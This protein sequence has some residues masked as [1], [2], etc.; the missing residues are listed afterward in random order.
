MS[1]YIDFY[2]CWPNSVLG[3]NKLFRPAVLRYV[4]RLNW[5][6]NKEEMWPTSNPHVRGNPL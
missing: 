1:R 4:R 3:L 2:D 5:L 6:I